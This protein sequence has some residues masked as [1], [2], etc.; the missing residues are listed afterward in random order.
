MQEEN[1]IEDDHYPDDCDS[2]FVPKKVETV[3]AI[4]F[5]EKNFKQL[6]KYHWISEIIKEDG[7]KPRVYGIMK[8]DSFYG[9]QTWEVNVGDWIVNQKSALVVIIDEVF[10]EL[11]ELHSVTKHN[12]DYEGNYP[13]FIKGDKV[14]FIGK[15]EVFTVEKQFLHYDGSDSFWGNVVLQDSN[16][17]LIKTHCWMIEHV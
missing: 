4:R 8:N 10:R 11:Y 13:R 12:I 1:F 6:K 2:L 9:S 15:E 3:R 14:R 17:E 7:D 5:L 16:K